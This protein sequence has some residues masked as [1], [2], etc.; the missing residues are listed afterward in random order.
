MGGGR[1]GT[2]APVALA[3]PA[4]LTDHDL[5][6]GKLLLDLPQ[7]VEGIVERLH[8]RQALPVGEQ[9]HGDEVHV[10]G[11]LR[12]AQPHVPRLGGRYRL[13]GATLDLADLEDQVRRRE[14]AMQDLLVTDDDPVDAAVD[15]HRLL[16]RVDLLAIVVLAGVQP[17]TRG[18]VEVLALGQRR[19]RRKLRG[20]VGP[21]TRGVPGQDLHVPVDGL[22]AG[23]VLLERAVPA[24]ERVVG[25]AGDFAVERR[26]LDG[27]MRLVPGDQVAEGDACRE[28]DRAE[29]RC[30]ATARSR[31]AGRGGRKPGGMHGDVGCG[32][33]A[34]VGGTRVH[35]FCN[36]T[37]DSR[38]DR[39]CTPAGAVRV[40]ATQGRAVAGGRTT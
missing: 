28:R 35:A 12:V 33:F 25:E 15:P 10:G 31:A 17:D 16:D 20:A 32:M 29:E 5:L 22:V 39:M 23:I 21:D 7:P 2:H 27:G 6:V 11:K 37:G 4:D 1:E 8:D 9:V 13:A 19:D 24:A 36:L 30:G 38:R 3:R 14:R 40:P 34:T 18:H 26:R